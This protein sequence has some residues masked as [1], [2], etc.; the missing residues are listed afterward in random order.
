MGYPKQPD[1]FDDI[2]VVL[3]LAFVG[4]VCLFIN[5]ITTWI[6]GG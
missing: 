4:F 3:A 5:P 6:L 1:I 2:L